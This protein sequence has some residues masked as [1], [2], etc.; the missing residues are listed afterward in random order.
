VPAAARHLRERTSKCYKPSAERPAIP[1]RRVTTSTR[2][3]PSARCEVRRECLDYIMAA[4]SGAPGVWG[5]TT[6][7]DRRKLKRVSAYASDYNAT[8]TPGQTPQT[9]VSRR[10][11]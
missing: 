9:M 4:E 7:L 8:T 3:G 2:L 1:R 10:N 5:G 11:V 6:G